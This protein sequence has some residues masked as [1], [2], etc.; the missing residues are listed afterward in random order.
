[1]Q[2][3]VESNMSIRPLPDE[4]A[5]QI[6]SSTTIVSLTGVVLELLKNS[7]DAKASKV[8]VT[9]DFARGSCTVEDDGLGIL[10]A[11]FSE[12]GGLGKLY[13]TSKFHSHEPHLGRYGTFLASL[14]AM[15][16]LTITSHHYAHRSHNL[17]SFHQGQP[18]ERQIPASAHN[19]VFAKHGT[20]VTVRN[21][22]E[23]C[24][25]A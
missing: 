13:W 4:V 12:Q 5:A 16:L 23:T 7:L 24:L 17:V 10:P 14:A 11:E 21:F 15:S 1:M 20:R 22:L 8:T 2:A 6:K 18:I 9:V 3:A 19:H 25:C